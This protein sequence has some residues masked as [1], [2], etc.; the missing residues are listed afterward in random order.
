MMRGNLG[1]DLFTTMASMRPGWSDPRLTK[2][3]ET[4]AAAIASKKANDVVYILGVGPP[5]AGW[6]SRR[7]MGAAVK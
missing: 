5:S 1:F 6:A 2:Q 7:G 3:W 4:P